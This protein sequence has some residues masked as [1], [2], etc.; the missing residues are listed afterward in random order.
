MSEAGTKKREIERGKE[1]ERER[2]KRGAIV[3]SEI[4][5]DLNRGLTG[6]A[7]KLGLAPVDSTY[8]SY[9]SGNADSSFFPLAQEGK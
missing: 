6:L 4:I 3:F 9:R 1:I 2:R 5:L 7:W 8:M